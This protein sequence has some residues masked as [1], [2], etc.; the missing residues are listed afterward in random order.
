M[1]RVVRWLYVVGVL[2]FVLAASSLW[3][4]Q[5]QVRSLQ[6]CRSNLKNLGTALEMYSTDAC[7]RYPSS[8]SS[9]TPD[10]LV[11]LPT[12]PASGRE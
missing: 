8:L 4:R 1:A 2:V 7:G 9:L 11:T 10:Y 12:C 6:D 5:C 3:A